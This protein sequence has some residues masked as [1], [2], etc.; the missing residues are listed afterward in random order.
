MTL[1]SIVAAAALLL[2]STAAS[3]T[4]YTIPNLPVAPVSAPFS[5]AV[6]VPSGA[7]VDKWSFTFPLTAGT[8]SATAAQLALQNIYSI[9]G[10]QIGLYDATSNALLGT[11]TQAGPA[12]FLNNL[13]LT[14]NQSYYFTVSGNG[15]GTA[16]GTY[17]FILAASP[18]SEPGT[19]AL[20]AA[21]LAC[22]GFV[23]GRRRNG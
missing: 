11:G 4:D 23:A 21:G 18:V 16:G 9:N 1:R 20:F 2:A 17:S 22:A 19:L 14:P 7:F 10:L 3:A 15:S 8:L 13:A 12:S 5:Q 6:T